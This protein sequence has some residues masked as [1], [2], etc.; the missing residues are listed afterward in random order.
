[1]RVIF[2]FLLAFPLAAQYRTV[3]PFSVLPGGLDG[4]NV[5]QARLSDPSLVIAWAGIRALSP[6]CLRE[7][8][9]YVQF[10]R[11]V[12][13]GWTADARHIDKGE[14]VVVDQEGH[15]LRMRCGNQLSPRPAYPLFPNPP[16]P[17]DD[18]RTVEWV[19]PPYLLPR[20]PLAPYLVAELPPVPEAG[21][22]RVHPPTP[23]EDN[24]IAPPFVVPVIIP[25]GVPFRP[26]V[27]VAPV[28]HVVPEPSYLWLAGAMLFAGIFLRKKCR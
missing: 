17:K 13:T 11:G 27:P 25:A 28:A 24:R 4:I 7:G 21:E 26:V 2:A 12:E 8:K 10:R 1:M 15:I 5:E 23:F 18:R 19:E 3:Y 14:P 16:A 20:L 22:P 6:A 9:F